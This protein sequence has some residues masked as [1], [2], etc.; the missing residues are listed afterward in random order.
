MSATF[1]CWSVVAGTCPHHGVSGI[2]N[3]NAKNRKTKFRNVKRKVCVE[4]ETRRYC[5]KFYEFSD[6]SSPIVESLWSYCG[7]D[8]T[9]SPNF[10]LTR[11]FV[12]FFLT[13][14]LVQQIPWSYSRRVSRRHSTSPNL[15]RKGKSDSK[16]ADKSDDTSGCVKFI[17]VA[18][19]FATSNHW[20]ARS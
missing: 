10:L 1:T 6:D 13:C 4:N 12:S 14:F 2:Q 8:V 18:S 3:K 20:N 11:R 19:Y 17:L 7:N 9:A 16:G 15:Q 5:Y